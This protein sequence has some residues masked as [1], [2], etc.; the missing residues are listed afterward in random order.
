[1]K[2]ADSWEIAEVTYDADNLSTPQYT[3]WMDVSWANEVFSDITMTMATRDG[4]ATLDVDLESYTTHTTNAVVISHTQMTSDTTTTEVK[5]A[6]AVGA[7][8]A[9]LHTRVRYKITL[10]GTWTGN[11]SCTV[12]MN[13]VA[14]RN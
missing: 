3:P 9:L 13:L 1:M 10:G 5:N 7:G 12:Q 8:T 2:Y 6:S 14:K 11:V 4:S